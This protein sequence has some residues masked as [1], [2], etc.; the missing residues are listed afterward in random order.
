MKIRIQGGR[1]IDPANGIDQQLD[2]FIAE[3]RI[4]AVAAELADFTADKV[5]DASGQWVFPGLVDLCAHMREPG[6]EH[7]ATIESETRAAAAA[8]ITTLCCPP[9]TM[10]IIDTPAVAELI[11]NRAGQAGFARVI[12][13]A[14][15]TQGLEGKQLS[16]MAALKAAGCPVVSNVYP[17]AN[18]QIQRLTMEYAR[19]HDLTVFINPTDSW[20]SNNG[21][22]HEGKVSTRLGLPGVPVAAET[23]AIARD[24]ALVDLIGARTHF[25]RLSSAA[26]VRM[27]A[28]AQ[29]DGLPVTADVCAHQLHL[30]EMDINEF[31]S[32]CHVMPPLR[33]QRDQQGLRD[34]VRD[35]VIHA[36]CSDHQPHE[37]DAKLA[38]FCATQP[39][40]SAL[41]TLLPLTMRLHQESDLPLMDAIHRLTKGPADVLALDAGTLSPKQLADICIYDPE[42]IWSLNDKTMIS[43]GLNT[44]FKG[45][46]FKGRVTHTLLEGKPVF[47]LTDSA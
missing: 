6:F 37:A 9:D 39:G 33:T 4:V 2:V 35:D 44:P 17:I 28:R 47:E 24:L 12:P 8:G 23:V 42:R 5:I 34:G 18:T 31:D 25:T 45:W 1:V 38:P 36:I 19:T 40:I 10:P 46:E 26:A 20:L 29:F 22:V 32:Q 3:G 15:L 13:I 21:C 14:A 7:K 11:I 30:T 27:I 16:E 41:T 43:R